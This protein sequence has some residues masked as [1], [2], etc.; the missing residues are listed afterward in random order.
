MD[1]AP[2]PPIYGNMLIVPISRINAL[3]SS[4]VVTKFI[5]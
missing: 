1:A 2:N 4:L 5:R 3:N